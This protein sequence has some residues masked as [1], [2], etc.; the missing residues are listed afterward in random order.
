MPRVS[1][2]MTAYDDFR[3]IDETVESILRQDFSDY[4]FIVVDDG[5][6]S[7]KAAIFARLARRD[8][9]IRIVSYETNAGP[10]E[11]GNRGI[12]QS[13]GDIIVR[14]DHDDISE[15]QRIG[16]LV[17]ALD[18]DPTLGLVGSCFTTIDE[19]GAP[20]EVIRMPG[21]DIEVRWASLFFNPFCH[22]SVAYRRSTFNAAGG[23]APTLLT[24]SDYDLWAR[25]LLCCRAANLQESLVGYR[26]NSCG[27]TSTYP[28]Q[29]RARADSV[30]KRLWA[31]L[32]RPYDDVVAHDLAQFV[33]GFDIIHDAGRTHAYRIVLRLLRRF[34]AEVR[35]GRHTEDTDVI[36][37]LVRTTVA[38]VLADPPPNLAATLNICWQAA[39]LE[40]AMAMKSFG[41][42]LSEERKAL[43][44]AA[45]KH[46]K[47]RRS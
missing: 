1:V 21:T 15:P 6:G 42:R 18:A 9:R 12:V 13:R 46:A 44:E 29:S 2:V 19:D 25:M 40:P 16:R 8:P 20:R 24:T 37:L 22:S 43:W 30:R 7:D 14:T 34:I 31:R 27:V 32:G 23:Y 4:E 10:A 3:F 38:R 35:S 11:A 28:Q 17:A 26:L 47:R 5:N 45:L 33:A 36:R 39:L 41:R